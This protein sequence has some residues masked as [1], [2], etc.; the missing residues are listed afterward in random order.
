[1][2]TTYHYIFVYVALKIKVQMLFCQ[3]TQH[4]SVCIIE[5]TQVS[6]SNTI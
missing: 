2:C 3:I 4:V 5:V 1:M 6:L